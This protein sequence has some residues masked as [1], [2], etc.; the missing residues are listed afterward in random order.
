[1]RKEPFI[2]NIEFQTLEE[3]IDYRRCSISK[4]LCFFL[5]PLPSDEKDLVAMNIYNEFNIH[6]A[7]TNDPTFACLF[8]AVVTTIF[9]STTYKYWNGYGRNHLIIFVNQEYKS[10][11]E[12]GA[13]IAVKS[14]YSPRQFR[15]NMDVATFLRVKNSDISEWET[16][17]PLLPHD[18]KILLTYLTASNGLTDT[19]IKDLNTLQISANHSQDFTFFEL[20]CPQPLCKE[21]MSL[22]DSKKVR[23]E[24][25]LQSVF[26]LIY[27]N[28]LSFQQRLFEALEAGTIPIILSTT[29]PLPFEDFIDWRKAAFRIPLSR[30]P[31]LHFILR[32]VSLADILEYR[33]KGRFF[34]ENYLL[35]TQ[36]IVKTLY[37]VIRYRLQMAASEDKAITAKPLFPASDI[38][39]LNSFFSPN[40]TTNFTRSV[41]DDEKVGPLEASFPSN[42]FAHN[43]TAFGMYAHT[44]WNNYPYFVD[45]SPEFFLEEVPL[46]SEAEF[47][48]D[49]SSGMRPISPGSGVTFSEALG[50]NRPR[51]QFTIVIVTFNRDQV[52]KT[53]LQDL[54]EV[55]FLNRIIVIWNN[56]GREPPLSWPRLNIPIYFIKAEKNSLNNR[57][58]PYDL[59]ETEA[60][61]SL[62]DDMDLKRPE[63]V[64]AFRV[65][66][67]DRT[68]IVGFPAR[69]HAR[70]G[71]SMFYNSNHTCQH[72]MIL[73]GAAFLHKNYLYA[74]TYGLPKII[75]QKVDELM[76]CEDI[77][78]NFLVAHLTRQPPIKTTSKW[79]IR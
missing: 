34:L 33:R 31:E 19:E 13:A 59:I 11:S 2:E 61:L 79:T 8:I 22:C 46:P 23:K 6:P 15:T 67:Q 30:L 18:R 49:T 62:D 25:L 16:L 12:I 40:S 66:R 53:R 27:P 47:F 10:E 24:H 9:N 44:I 26:T 71:D 20:N 4:K 41:N 32:S 73:T 75:H 39:E 28:T 63:I 60:I 50:S 58:I 72:S 64:F 55:P 57:F 48:N 52:L 29:E 70:F 38:N 56:I 1:M 77:A 45:H 51:E 43:F 3:S 78:M 21:R 54:H 65:W 17:S 14:F 5:Y 69:H 76:N 35:N 42:K 37:S 36:V 68:K 74:Y 7:Q